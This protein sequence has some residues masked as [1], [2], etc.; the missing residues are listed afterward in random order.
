MLRNADGGGGGVKF[1]GKKRYEDVKFN[2][3]SVTRGGW[4]S[5]FQG[6][7]RS[8]TLEWPLTRLMKTLHV[9][10]CGFQVVHITLSSRCLLFVYMMLYISHLVCIHMYVY[11]YNAYLYVLYICI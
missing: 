2:V 3:I 6:K 5:N 10:T 7:K 4:G 11:I 9:M 1:S 8:V